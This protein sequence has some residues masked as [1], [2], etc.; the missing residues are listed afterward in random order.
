MRC[1]CRNGRAAHG[2]EAGHLNHGCSGTGKE[3]NTLMEQ[4]NVVATTVNEVDTM[5]SVHADHPG[6]YLGAST[7]LWDG[8][9]RAAHS[10]FADAPY[11]TVA[12]EMSGLPSGSCSLCAPEPIL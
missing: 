9:L 8:S 5:H 1:P 4:S 2:A 6:A 12:R 3:F 10:G 7:R 11:S